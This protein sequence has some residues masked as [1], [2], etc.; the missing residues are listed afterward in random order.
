M[1]AYFVDTS[2]LIKRYVTEMG[3]GW[4]RSWINPTVGNITFVS[5]LATVELVSALARRQRE[6]TIPIADFVQLRNGFLVHAQQ[7]YRVIE[8][9]RR[10]ATRAQYYTT[11]HQLRALDSIQ[12]ASA[13]A[14]ARA[15]GI[16]PIFVG[17]D[18]KLLSAAAAEGFAVENANLHL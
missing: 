14:A 6:G 18:N 13:W 17:A 1:T 10:V 8:F 9:G 7:E 3:S 15:L 2:A 11:Q 4:V 12:L 16:S 5:R